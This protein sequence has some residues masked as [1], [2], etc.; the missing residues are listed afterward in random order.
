MVE[1]I[2]IQKRGRKPKYATDLERQEVHSRYMKKWRDE[3][4]HKIK[5][6]N[7]DKLYCNICKKN[8]NK[9]QINRH[10]RTYAH[11]S[12]VMQQAP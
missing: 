1:P 9:G 6:Y 11:S 2:Q 5:K 4:P 7:T 3:H 8:V 10:W 12:L